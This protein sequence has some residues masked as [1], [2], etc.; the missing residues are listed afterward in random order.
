MDAKRIN[1]ALDRVTA[2]AMARVATVV[3]TEG[4]KVV[5]HHPDFVEANKALCD[6]LDAFYDNPVNV[7]AEHQFALVP[8]ATVPDVGTTYDPKDKVWMP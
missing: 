5:S 4:R 8:L 3:L 7:A 1:R 2:E 6:A